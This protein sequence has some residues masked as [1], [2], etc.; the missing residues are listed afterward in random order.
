VRRW[1]QL[2]VRRERE[3][4]E[5]LVARVKASGFEAIV[6]TVDTVV[7]GVRYRDVK[8]GLTIPPKLTLKTLLDMAKYPKWWGNLLTTEP[9][10]FASLDMNDSGGTVADLLSKIFDP[11]ITLDDIKWLK[12]IWDGKLL[13]KGVQSVE[14]AVM[15]KDAGVDGIILSTHGGRQMDKAPVP[16]ELLP[17]VRKAVGKDMTVLIDGGVMSGTDILAAIGLGANAVLVGRAYLY[18][19]MAGG[20]EGVERVVQLLKSEIEM[21]MRL[22]GITKLE[23][24]TPDRV[25]IRN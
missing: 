1:Y 24:L 18:G 22:L 23:E 20:E 14:D 25:R 10:V 5:K 6:L 17:E 13:I 7:G 15:L 2:Y 21:S 9:L 19:L 16:L 4:N 12:T 8:N 11:S 3:P